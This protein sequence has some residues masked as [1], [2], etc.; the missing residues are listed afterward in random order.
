MLVI[1]V[2]GIIQAQPIMDW[3]RLRGYTAPA[4]IE[5]VASDTT[6]TDTAKHLFYLNRPDIASKAAFRSKC[7]DYGE[8]TIVIGCYQSPQRGIYVLAVDDSRLQGIEQVTAAHEML[9][10]AYDRLKSSEKKKVDQELQDYAEHGLTDERIKGILDSYKQTEPGQQLNEM[11]SIFGTEIAILPQP[12]E[13][14]Y[15]RYFSDRHKVAAYAERYQS[16]FTSRR[17]QIADYDA[18]LAAEN[19]QVKA[20]LAKLDAQSKEID[21]I[22]QQLDNLRSSG[23]IA[24]YNAGVGDYNQRVNAYNSL[25]DETKTQISKYNQEVD[26]RNALAAETTELQQAIDSSVLPSSQ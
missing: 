15:A 4:N 14:Y 5:A 1:V 3:W 21:A 18:R 20:N 13:Q 9:H 12:L 8:K 16:A 10:A 25:L 17:Q 24:V 26:E 11:H 23:N 19:K 6:M 22:Q 7:P 2:A